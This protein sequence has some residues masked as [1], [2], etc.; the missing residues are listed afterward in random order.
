MRQQSSGQNPEARDPPEPTGA[1]SALAAELIRILSCHCRL[2]APAP[3]PPPAGPPSAALPCRIPHSPLHQISLLSARHHTPRISF[4]KLQSRRAAS[5]T[6]GRV[7]FLCPS[8]TN[9]LHTAN[10]ISKVP[11][12][13]SLLSS[14]AGRPPAQGPGPGPRLSMASSPRCLFLILLRESRLLHTRIPTLSTLRQSEQSSHIKAG[15]SSG[16]QSPYLC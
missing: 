8:I 5:E 12:N 7:P 16:S 10:S 9:Q 4:L 14:L 1:A 6:P 3:G 15:R 11:G 13:Y 2:T